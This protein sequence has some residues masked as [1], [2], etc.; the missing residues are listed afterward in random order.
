MNTQSKDSPILLIYDG[1]CELCT[2]L[3]H[4]VEKRSDGKIKTIS[5]MEFSAS[6]LTEHDALTYSEDAS[7][8][9]I[10]VF[11][12]GSLHT[13]PSA[14]DLLLT[15]YPDLKSVN[16]LANKL[17]LRRHAITGLQITTSA[18]RRLCRNCPGWINKMR[19]RRK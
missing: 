2:N 6:R 3:A 5:W 11:Y 16:W 4:F 13:G 10:G 9:S 14:W 15:H 19:R 18:A 17:H 8:A 1:E 7:P 12:G